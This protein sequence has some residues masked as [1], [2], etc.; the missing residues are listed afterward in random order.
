MRE[1][2]R[3]AFTVLSLAGVALAHT[4]GYWA[5]DIVHGQSF[6]SLMGHGY[7]NTISSLLMPAAIATIAWLAVVAARAAGPGTDIEW[8]RLALLTAFL[9]AV[10]EFV[11]GLGAAESV[12]TILSRPSLWWA[13][14][15]AV[16]VARLLTMLVQAARH[17][18]DR[19]LGSSS[20]S[21][22]RSTPQ[23]P[24]LS[25]PPADIAWAS[26]LARGPPVPC[27]F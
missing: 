16:A 4:F 6:D 24:P 10:Q 3:L 27:H 1:K 7:L 2:R 11:E 13:L 26:M 18:A 14:A 17:I 22:R 25:A 20:P 19:L 21:H 23:R 12:T 15:A 9:L 5:A 8:K